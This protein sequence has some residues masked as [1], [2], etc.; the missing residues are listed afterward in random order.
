MLGTQSDL[1]HDHL[2][3]YSLVIH[4]TAQC[5]TLGYLSLSNPEEVISG[6]SIKLTPKQLKANYNSVQKVL[7]MGGGRKCDLRHVG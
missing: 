4:I 6:W 5:Y 2:P 1:P 3:D 7:G